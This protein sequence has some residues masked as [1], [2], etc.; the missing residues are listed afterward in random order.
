M[1]GDLGSSCS[2]S[3]SRIP[4]SRSGFSDSLSL[5]PDDPD[6]FRTRSKLFKLVVYALR[7]VPKSAGRFSLS[8]SMACVGIGSGTF[9]RVG[10]SLCVKANE[11][12]S[13]VI[14][15]WKRARV[16]RR[17]S[18]TALVRKVRTFLKPACRLTSSSIISLSDSLLAL[19]S[20]KSNVAN[21]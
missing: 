9:L 3:S 6:R 15:S 14:L 12:W 1:V 8:A 7:K 4:L 20:R 19:A 16:A 5:E 18:S 11:D 10:E 2:G 17:T 21:L 13:S